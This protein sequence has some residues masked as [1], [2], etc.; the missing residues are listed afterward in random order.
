[1]N[2]M[3][4]RNRVNNMCETKGIEKE[5][6]RERERERETHTHTQERETKNDIVGAL[7][8]YEYTIIVR[9]HIQLVEARTCAIST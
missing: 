7:C 8:W 4:E 6:E 3:Q 9:M 2:T 5:R 1:M